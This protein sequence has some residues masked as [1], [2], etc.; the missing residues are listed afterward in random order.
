MTIYFGS[1]K[2]KLYFGQIKIAMQLFSE[3][4]VLNGKQ[5]FSS[6]DYVLTDKNGVYLTVRKEEILN[7][8]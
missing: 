1:Q 2:Q 7:V 3:I 4:P 8:E 6:D 5:L